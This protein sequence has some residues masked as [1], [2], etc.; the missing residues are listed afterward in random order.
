MAE[1]ITF[2]EA[3]NLLD[4]GAM[5]TDM[6]FVTDD[7]K[8]GTG[9]E[10]IEIKK[11]FKHDFVSKKERAMLAKAQPQQAVKKNPHHYENSTRNIALPNGEIRKVSIRLIRRFN[12]KIVT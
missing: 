12:G 11:G 9:G 4:S 3:L 7:E 2:K 10:W 6:A 8:R 5:F 1:T